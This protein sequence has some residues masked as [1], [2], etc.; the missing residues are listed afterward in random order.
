MI[1]LKSINVG[2]QFEVKSAIENID[3]SKLKH[4]SLKY[5][6]V[7][8]KNSYLDSKEEVDG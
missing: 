8:Y 1:Q 3:K 4:Y 5:N 7:D 6:L 2:V